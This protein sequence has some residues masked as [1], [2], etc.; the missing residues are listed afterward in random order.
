MNFVE[1]Q[2]ERS[3]RRLN[4]GS[5]CDFNITVKFVLDPLFTP[6]LHLFTD[7]GWHLEVRLSEGFCFL[8]TGPSDRGPSNNLD[9]L[10]NF[11]SVRLEHWSYC[12]KFCWLVA[13]FSSHIFSQPVNQ[14]WIDD[15]LLIIFSVSKI[16]MK[17]NWTV[18][19]NKINIVDKFR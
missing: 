5:L 11:A 14:I 15:L 8:E 1:W 17:N 3:L 7:M 19:V 10:D 4:V 18:L 13:T 6:K 16:D 2:N 9:Y 12:W